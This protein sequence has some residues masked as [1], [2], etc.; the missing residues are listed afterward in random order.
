MPEIRELSEFFYVT[1]RSL[2]VAVAI[3]R[4]VAV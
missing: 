2:L 3:R 4:D 1:S